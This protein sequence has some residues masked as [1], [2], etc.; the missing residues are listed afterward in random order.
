MTPHGGGKLIA[1]DSLEYTTILQWIRD[2]SP[3]GASTGPKLLSV[4]ALPGGFRILESASQQQ[5]MAVVGIYSDGSRVDLTSMVR[6]ISSDEA[7]ATVSASGLVTPKRNGEVTVLVR[8]LGQVDAMRIA[9]ALRPDAPVSAAA[10]AVRN[11]ID[12][13]IFSKLRQVKV[14]PSA[15]STDA[16]FLRRVYLDLIG[17]LPLRKKRWPS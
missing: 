4:Q 14:A 9:V 3:L 5:Q 11:F 12:E 10:P 17:T 2:G 7:V 15:L 1:K 6:Y 8:T 13:A 16:Q